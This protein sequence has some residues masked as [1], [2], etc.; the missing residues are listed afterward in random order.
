MPS[1]S[2]DRGGAG[3]PAFLAPRSLYIHVPLCAS[4]CAYCDFYSL[5]ASAYSEARLAGLVE[6]I[7]ARAGALCERFGA[8]DFDT[9]YVGGGTP[10]ALPPRLLGRLLSGI[11][12]I[13]PSPREWTVEANPESLDAPA[14]AT[15]M[16]QG[17]N[18]VSIGVQSLDPRKLSLLG[19]PHSAQEAVE[20]VGLAAS[21]GLAVSADLMA[22]LPLLRGDGGP[23][24]PALPEQIVRLLDLGIAHLSLYDLIL[25]DDTALARRVGRGE[26]ELPGEDE[27]ASERAAAEDALSARGFR[28]YEVSNYAPQ[29][30]ECAHNLVYWRMGSYIGA[31]PGAVSTLQAS[32]TAQPASSFPCS[33]RIEEAKDAASYGLADAAAASETFIGEKDSMFETIMMSFRTVFGLDSGAFGS[34]FGIDPA[35]VIGGT[36]AAWAER[37]VAGPSGPALDAEGLDI[38][39]RFLVDCLMELEGGS[40]GLQARVGAGIA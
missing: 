29:G 5:P 24:V 2:E 33:L 6:A 28:R 10:T 20:A 19:R 21:S 11:A 37:V 1:L 27:A 22:G 26:L 34:R 8:Q 15:M 14:I 39:N 32:R 31:G 13:A 3:A 23:S 4:R 25:E 12:A 30:K 18:R 36:L 38:L 40:T 7:L 9:V 35:R 17:V 16:E